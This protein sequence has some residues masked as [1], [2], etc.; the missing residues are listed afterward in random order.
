MFP[1]RAES[2][3]GNVEKNAGGGR[4][5]AAAQVLSGTPEG[6]S[7]G[8]SQRPPRRRGPNRRPRLPPHVVAA[9]CLNPNAT[10]KVGER[11]VGTRWRTPSAG[12]WLRWGL[13]GQRKEVPQA[14][15][16]LVAATFE[17]EGAPKGSRAY[18]A[19][20][21]FLSIQIAPHLNLAHLSVLC[22]STITL[23]ALAASAAFP[24]S[25]GLF[26]RLVLC[27]CRSSTWHAYARIFMC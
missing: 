14:R 1:R 24:F 10:R 11:G 21:P 2:P 12:S 18:W 8:P 17:A 22:P 15:C 3:P 9:R 26:Q 27:T 25:T 16:W 13:A 6:S 19:G 4:R 5:R 7:R 23:C 20:K